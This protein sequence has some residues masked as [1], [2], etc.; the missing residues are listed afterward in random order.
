MNAKPQHEQVLE[1]VKAMPGCTLTEVCTLV[2]FRRASVSSRLHQL[3]CEGKIRH[4]NNRYYPSDG[5]PQKTIPKK[6]KMKQS[7]KNNLR[8]IELEEL[9]IE[10]QLWKEAAIK[11]YPDLGVKPEILAARKIVAQV[12]KNMG[13][14]HKEAETLA[15]RLDESPLIQVALLAGAE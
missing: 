8:L 2:D 9:V 13:D 4:E 14:K 6:L 10:L 12:F 3:K 1:I 11:R 5:T 7:T 15:G